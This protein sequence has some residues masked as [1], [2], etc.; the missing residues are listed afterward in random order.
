MVAVL[1][2]LLTGPIH[3]AM[4]DAGCS[5][6]WMG[7]YD[8]GS[9]APGE[10]KWIDGTIPSPV[11]YENWDVDEPNAYS[12]VTGSVGYLRER[13]DDASLCRDAPSWEDA[14]ASDT[15]LSCGVCWRRFQE[16]DV[17]LQKSGTVDVG[18]DSM[19]NPGDVI[20][21]TL[22][23]KN[24]GTVGLVDI[25]VTDF[26][27]PSVTCPG[28]NPIP[29]LAVGASEICTGTYTITQ[30]D[31][32]AGEKT[33]NARVSGDSATTGFSADDEDN[34]TVSLP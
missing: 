23:V 11:S 2:T 19:L 3:A 17:E 31:I 34:H 16:H 15:R 25:D 27:L 9:A 6:T 1:G 33:N 30:A 24:I 8:I 28:G 5:I 22:A 18:A 4:I 13:T 21:Y 20:D 29:S 32:D 26:S 14:S 10:F 12:G 7:M